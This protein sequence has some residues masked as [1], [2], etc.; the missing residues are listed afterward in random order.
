MLGV[1]ANIGTIGPIFGGVTGAI[2]RKF[3]L[4]II[5]GRCTEWFW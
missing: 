3:D 1:R 5:Y 4:N 2:I